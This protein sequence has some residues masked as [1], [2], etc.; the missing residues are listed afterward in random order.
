MT[1]PEHSIWLVSDTPEGKMYDAII[2][3][4]AEKY[5]AP[6]FQSHITL[7]GKLTMEQRKISDTI[8]A[9]AEEQRQFLVGFTGMEMRER[10]WHQA[11]FLRAVVLVAA[12]NLTHS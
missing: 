7:L 8:R 5:D 6:E 3:R 4:L 1:N 9:L 11:L 10:L 12:I 2:K